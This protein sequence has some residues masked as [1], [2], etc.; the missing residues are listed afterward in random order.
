MSDCTP[1]AI[2]TFLLKLYA[3][4]LSARN[5]TPSQI[6]DTFDLLLEGVIDS[7]GLLEMI[8]RLEQEFQIAIDLEG[9]DAEKITVLGPLCAYIAGSSNPKE[10]S[11]KV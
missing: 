3:D 1:E 6:P 2:R 4:Q 9:L 8:G 10:P 11:S 5:L 7:L